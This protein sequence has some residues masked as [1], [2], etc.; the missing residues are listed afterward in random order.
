MLRPLIPANLRS[1]A[2]KDVAAALLHD[3]PR[4]DG[5]RIM[6]SAQMQGMG[7]SQAAGGG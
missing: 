2:V 7:G 4:A 6:L 5:K 3:V 1:I